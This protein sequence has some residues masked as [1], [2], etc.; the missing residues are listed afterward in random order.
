MKSLNKRIFFTECAYALGLAGLAMGTA[1]MEAADF[2]VSMVVA[3]A[4]LVYLKLSQTLGFFTFGMA[5]YTL[6]AVLLIVLTIVLR[7]F[8]ISWLFSIVTAVLYGFLLDGAIALVSLFAPPLPAFRLA[9]YL[10]GMLLCSAGVSLLFHT[11]LAPE[12]YELFVKEL[13]AKYGWNIHK[14]KTCYDC[15]SCLVAVMMSFAFFRPWHFEGVK[16]GT[17]VCALLNGWLIGRFTYF[18]EN[19]WEFRDALPARRYFVTG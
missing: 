8:R 10:L 2:G 14:V 1:L 17:V 7:R 11:Y 19:R 16:A 5:E 13:S 3:P 15:V 9:A 6:Q 12:V 18:F 4:Y